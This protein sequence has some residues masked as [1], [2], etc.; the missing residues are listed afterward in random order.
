M[1]PLRLAVPSVSPSSETWYFASSEAACAGRL[2]A[3][4]IATKDNLATKNNPARDGAMAG[5]IRFLRA[6]D[7]ICNALRIGLNRDL[8]R[9]IWRAARQSGFSRV[10]LSTTAR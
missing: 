7:V 4:S 6:L 2:A 10:L 5:F 3:A 8:F 1:P 9:G